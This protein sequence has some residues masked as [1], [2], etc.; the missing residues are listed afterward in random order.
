MMTTCHDCHKTLTSPEHV[1]SDLRI[2]CHDCGWRV[3]AL[4]LVEA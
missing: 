1:A 2:L 4:I 3:A